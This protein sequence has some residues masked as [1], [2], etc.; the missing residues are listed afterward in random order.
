MH[1]GTKSID[2]AENCIDNATS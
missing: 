2:E 1:K